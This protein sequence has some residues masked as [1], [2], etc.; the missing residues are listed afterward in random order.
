MAGYFLQDRDDTSFDPPPGLYKFLKAGKPPVYIGFGS[1]VVNNPESLTELV[2][3]AVKLA[4]VRALISKGWLGLGDDQQS[5]ENVYSIGDVPHSWLFERV[6]AVV[7]HGGAGTTAASLRAGKPSV[8]VPFF[9][10]VRFFSSNMT[11]YN[12]A[13]SATQQHFW[14]NVVCNAGCG[15][16]PIPYLQLTPQK[17]AGQIKAALEPAVIAKATE[18]G[19][20]IQTENGCDVAATGLHRFMS[21]DASRCHLIRDRIAVWKIKGSEIQISTLAAAALVESGCLRYSQL[22]MYVANVVRFPFYEPD[23]ALGLD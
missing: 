22:R 15:P 18:I 6:S 14:G 5:T 17:L 9:G 12:P 10:D 1:I 4:G 20:T 7:H 16:R 19:A 11:R 13:N 3:Q 2:L 23:T 8:V 21:L